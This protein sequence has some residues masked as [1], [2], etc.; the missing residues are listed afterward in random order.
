[1]F[2][3]VQEQRKIM[4]IRRNEG[5]TGVHNIRVDESMGETDEEQLQVSNQPGKEADE[6]HNTPDIDRNTLK[7]RW[8]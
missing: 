3:L 6:D 4:C 7:L 1:M 2:M 5:L 8:R